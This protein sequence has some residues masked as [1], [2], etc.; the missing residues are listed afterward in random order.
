MYRLE[1][2]YKKLED[3]QRQ[4]ISS[5][6]YCCKEC[7]QTYT[8]FDIMDLYNFDQKCMSCTICSGEVQSVED[9]EKR[10]NAREE[11]ARFN[12]KVSI[13]YLIDEITF[14]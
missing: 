7:G 9:K 4:N 14:G 10:H 8:D 12:T 2:C 13:H 1:S 11:I 6:D 5:G 3:S